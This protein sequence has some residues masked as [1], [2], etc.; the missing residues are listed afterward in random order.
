M[1]EDD[2]AVAQ[3]QRH[4]RQAE[5]VRV[6]RPER[7]DRADEVVAEEADGAPRERGQLGCRCRAVAGDG[8]GGNGVG[9]AVVAERPADDLAR[10]VAD[11]RV[12][13][14]ALALLGRLEQERRVVAAELEERRDGGLAV[15]DEAVAQGDQVVLA[16][17]GPDLVERRLDPRAIGW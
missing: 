5:G 11:E 6:G 9:I 12:A 8:V 17:E 2:E 10:V 15:G 16:R 4:V 7:L 3:H 14:E 1:V 13:A